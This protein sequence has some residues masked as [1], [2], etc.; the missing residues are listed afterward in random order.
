MKVKSKIVKKC[1]VEKFVKK[2][3]SKQIK[4]ELDKVL[5]SADYIGVQDWRY[6]FEDKYYFIYDNEC[7]LFVFDEKIELWSDLDN[8]FFTDKKFAYQIKEAKNI[9]TAYA[10]FVAMTME[11]E[12]E[13]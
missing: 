9:H 1:N 8:V 6:D 5:A 7:Y 12:E 4:E 11:A 2:W 13:G 10:H 3:N